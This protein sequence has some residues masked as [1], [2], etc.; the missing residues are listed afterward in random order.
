MDKEDVCRVQTASVIQWTSTLQLS[1]I[2]QKLRP[3]VQLTD[4]E[5]IKNGI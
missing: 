2:L 4:I 5:A 3:C 1:N